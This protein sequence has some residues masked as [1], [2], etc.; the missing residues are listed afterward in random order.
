M[1]THK[2]IN[3]TGTHLLEEAD[4]PKKSAKKSAKRS[5]PSTN[6]KK[7]CRDILLDACQDKR[8]MG[9]LDKTQLLLVHER[10]LLVVEVTMAAGAGQTASRS[11]LAEIAVVGVLVEV[12]DSGR[13]AEG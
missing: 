8:I 7:E 3:D 10:N 12:K 5:P 4:P 13:G 6:P 9:S 11:A 2:E 1:A